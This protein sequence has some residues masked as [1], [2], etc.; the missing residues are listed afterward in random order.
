[1][2]TIFVTSNLLWVDG[3][4]IGGGGETGEQDISPA[5][6]EDSC[7]KTTKQEAIPH[8]PLP[9]LNRE[10]ICELH[11]SL[12][13]ELSR[14]QSSEDFIERWH[15]EPLAHIEDLSP[16]L[17]AT[18]QALPIIPPLRRKRNR[19][20]PEPPEGIAPFWDFVTADG[21]L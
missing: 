3:L 4:N 1:V 11:R 7:F 12:G 13:E 16:N 20:I 21:H 19:I 17:R 14:L 2:E 9:T 10:V 6:G 18:L 8:A 5:D 15:R